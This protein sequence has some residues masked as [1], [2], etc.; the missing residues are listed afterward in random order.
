MAQISFCYLLIY[1]AIAIVIVYA[2]EDKHVFGKKNVAYCPV[3]N[4]KL[5]L[6]TNAHTIVELQYG[7]NIFVVNEAAAHMYI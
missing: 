7:Q 2:E 6:E 5:H 3:T 4:T 1:L